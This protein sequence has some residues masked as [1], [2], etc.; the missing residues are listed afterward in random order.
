[1]A[2]AEMSEHLE[3][4]RLQ[5]LVERDMETADRLHAG[6]YQLITPGGGALSKAEYLGSI[7]GGSLRYRVFEPS[8]EISLRIS[9]E[10]AALRYRCHIEVMS[11]DEIVIIDA[12]H[13]DIWQCIDECW[14]AVWS[15]ATAIPT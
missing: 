14:Q 13:T 12:W 4:A 1:V 5:A 2:K 9:G 15:Q 6:A 7:L 8:G 10:M 11:D 3:R